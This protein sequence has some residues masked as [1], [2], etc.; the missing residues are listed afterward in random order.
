MELKRQTM[1]MQQVSLFTRERIEIMPELDGF[2][3]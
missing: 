1:S 2:P 3:A